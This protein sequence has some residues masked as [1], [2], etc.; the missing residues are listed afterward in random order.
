MFINQGLTPNDVVSANKDMLSAHSRSVW[1][2]GD[3][4]GLN[5]VNQ[6]S[7]QI[8]RKQLPLVT[9]PTAENHAWPNILFRALLLPLPHE[10]STMLMRLRNWLTFYEDAGFFQEHLSS[11][12]MNR[13]VRSSQIL[14]GTDE[15]E[16]SQIRSQG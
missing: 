4:D 7:M 6:T 1:Y 3:R 2:Q 8:R 9:V 12:S 15:K 16:G 13:M 10:S 5:T 14:D 11:G